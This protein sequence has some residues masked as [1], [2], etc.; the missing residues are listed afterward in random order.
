MQTHSQDRLLDQQLRAFLGPIDEPAL[1][2][3][4]AELEWVELA[5]GATLMAQGEPG[6]AMYLSI[7]GR[8]R[9]YVRDDDG[10]EHLVREMARGQVVGEM[11]LYTDEP[12]SATVVAIRDSVL[13]RLSKPAFQ[14]LLE[15]SVQASIALTRQLIRRLQT[16]QTRS[17]LARPVTLAL[18][19][20]TVGVDLATLAALLSDELRRIVPG[21][22]VCCVDAAMVDRELGSPGAARSAVAGADAD[23]AASV[24]SEAG[25]DVDRRIGIL[26][27]GI[28][29]A[30]DVVLLL[31]D[32]EPTPWTERCSRRSDEIVLLADADAP[33]ALHVSETQFLMRRH[34]RAEAAE[35][36]VLL[37]PA[38]RRCPQG[39]RHW[40]ARRPVSAHVHL[41]PALPRDISRLARLLAQQGVG[42]V[43]A[44]GGARGLAHLGVMR[45]LHDQGVEIDVVGGTSIGAV[46]AA[47]AA[48]DRPLDEVMT[49]TR[50]AFGSNPT[51]DYNPL[52]LISLIAGRRLRR[53]VAEA[54]QQLF[55][56]TP[57]IEDLWKTFHCVA[58]NYSQASE[59]VLR[60]GALLPALRASMAIP[61]AL[62]PVPIDGDLL[63]D[64]GTF[65]NFPVDVMRAER[66]VGRVIGVDLSVRKPRRVD[67]DEVPSWWALLRDRL[68]P[69]AARRYRLPSLMAY[70]M[71]VT[72]LYS[73]SRQ[74]QAR[75]LTDLHFNPPLDRVGMLQWN[76]FDSIVE[77]GRSHAAAVLAAMD[78]PALQGWRSAA[79]PLAA[80]NAGVAVDTRAAPGMT[81][82]PTQATTQNPTSP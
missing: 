45:A 52:P 26:L 3:L 71:N 48:S 59:Q 47:L 25:T 72:V 56:C 57:D 69:R 54:G 20:I 27:D 43:L 6:D 41:R 79:Q 14:R 80:G 30:H 60:S 74:R 15:N 44:G 31:A 21:G 40:L 42:L 58:S 16:V 62:P 34:S 10:A 36:L 55:K 38:E 49:V 18:L 5:A 75:K 50:R 4:R 53:V 8:L 46:M 13:V 76:K 2:L 32:A 61:G 19:P 68:R 22:R 28:E 77:Q 17:S 67:L 35:I 11:A 24:I 12:R 29:A 1:Q 63:C 7:S 66:G 65:N 81:Q 9:A 51:G 64:G 78:A 70:L 33:A 73:T 82:A 39:T 37:H 23:A